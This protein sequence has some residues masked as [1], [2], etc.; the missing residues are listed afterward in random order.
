K[1]G[2]SPVNNAT[3]MLLPADITLATAGF[4]PSAANFSD[5]TTFFN[6]FAD[7]FGR[8]LNAGLNTTALGGYVSVDP[9]DPFGWV[10]DAS[11]CC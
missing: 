7:A 5:K 1:I 4:D 11:T 3:I 6:Y 10:A 9:T 2:Q 8:L